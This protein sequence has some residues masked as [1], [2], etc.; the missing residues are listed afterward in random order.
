MWEEKDFCDRD[1]ATALWTGTHLGD[2]YVTSL[3]CDIDLPA[4]PNKLK[5]LAAK[6]K[7][8]NRELSLI[9]I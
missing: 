9:H 3:Y 4:V 5:K 1:M 2:V 7:H 6:A 8:E